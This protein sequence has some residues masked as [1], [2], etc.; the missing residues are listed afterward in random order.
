MGYDKIRGYLMAW[1]TKRLC[2]NCGTKMDTRA[3]VCPKC[4][5]KQVSEK[6]TR[7]CNVNSDNLVAEQR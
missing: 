3:K 5:F 4:G 1:R 2:W 7:A 6:E